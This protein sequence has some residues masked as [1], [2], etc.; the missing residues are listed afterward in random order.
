MKI[1]GKTALNLCVAMP[2]SRLVTNF[3]LNIF[4]FEARVSL[5]TLLQSLKLN[6][7]KIT[8]FFESIFQFF[9][10]EKICQNSIKVICRFASKLELGPLYSPVGAEV[11]RTLVLFV[12]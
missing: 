8:E 5:Q 4:I 3:Q 10:F 2:N 11:K 9:L 7:S 12:I 1:Y 6:T